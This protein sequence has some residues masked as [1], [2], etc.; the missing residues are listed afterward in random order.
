MIKTNGLV[1]SI[2]HNNE[3][4][5]E[6]KNCIQKN[7]KYLLDKKNIILVNDEGEKGYLKYAPYK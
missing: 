7:H 4:I 5:N 3:I 1:V 2:N 6:S